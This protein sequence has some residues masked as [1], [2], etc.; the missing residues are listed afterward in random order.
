MPVSTCVARRARAGF[1]WYGR[2]PVMLRT[3]LFL[4][5]VLAAAPASAAPRP[6]GVEVRLE[7]ERGA[8]TQ[9]CP[10]ADAIRREVAAELGEDRFTETGPWRLHA[11]VARK[12]NGAY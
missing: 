4:I 8:G 11:A 1:V 3:A 6:R 10:G 2:R 9:L 7:Y 12:K 5:I